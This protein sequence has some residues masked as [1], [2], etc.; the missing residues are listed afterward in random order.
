MLT[1]CQAAPPAV[2]TVALRRHQRYYARIFVD[3][4]ASHRGWP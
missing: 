4:L 2:T 3:T 1:D